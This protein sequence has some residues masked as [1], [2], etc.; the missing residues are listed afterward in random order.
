[1]K[2]NTA[3]AAILALFACSAVIYGIQFVLFHVC[4]KSLDEI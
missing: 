3:I 4:K 1:M 2:R